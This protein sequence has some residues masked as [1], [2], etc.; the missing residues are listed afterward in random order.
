[1][2]ATVELSITEWVVLAL[3]VESPKHGF[4][5]SAATG[6]DGEL[7]R[8]WRVPRPVVYRSLTRL[9]EEGLVESTVTEPGERGPNRTIVAATSAGTAAVRRWLCIPVKHVRDVRSELLVKL[10]L[11]NRR[12]ED[13]RP[14]LAAQREVFAPMA[15]ALQTKLSSEAGFARTIAALRWQNAEAVLRFL[16]DPAVINPDRS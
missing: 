15:I 16:D 4:A 6:T 7:G 2:S 9:V 8:V 12:G 14:L 13:P 5:V 1:M 3:V 10:A 11:I